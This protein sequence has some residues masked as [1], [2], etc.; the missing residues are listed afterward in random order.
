MRPHATAA[1]LA[2]M[3]LGAACSRADGT[4]EQHLDGLPLHST[5]VIA[6][7]GALPEC[8]D[9]IRSGG[10]IVWK[11]MVTCNGSPEPVSGCAHPFSDPPTIEIVYRTS[12]WDG[13]AE[14]P[15]LSTLAHELCHVCGYT[16]EVE[17]TACAQRAMALHPK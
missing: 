16:S 6:A 3:L 14:R 2:L 11:P 13:T 5:D 1:S 9:A 7:V 10:I 15:S 17:A 12:A 8:A 4:W